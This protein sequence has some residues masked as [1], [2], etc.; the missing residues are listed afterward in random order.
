ML[1]DVGVRGRKEGRKEGYLKAIT[2]AVYRVPPRPRREKGVSEDRDFSE[3]N[4]S[5][6]SVDIVRMILFLCWKIAGM[7][8]DAASDVNESPIIIE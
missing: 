2:R 7:L 5:S 3:H 6:T 1:I 8:K 4:G